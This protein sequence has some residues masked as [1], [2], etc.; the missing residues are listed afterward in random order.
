MKDIRGIAAVRDWW[1][2]GTLCMS[3]L[4]V[5]ASVSVS[6]LKVALE[7]NEGG[8]LLESFISLHKHNLRC[9]TSMRINEYRRENLWSANKAGSEVQ[10]CP[11]CRIV[12]A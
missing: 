8:L 1:P 5:L 7:N 11:E 12:G 9:I 2:P 4:A 10:Y 6:R 3:R